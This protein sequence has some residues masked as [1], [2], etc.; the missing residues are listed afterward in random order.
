MTCV[1]FHNS[2]EDVVHFPGLPSWRQLTYQVK[3]LIAK[4][5]ELERMRRVEKAQ[6]KETHKAEAVN[7]V[8]K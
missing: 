6:Q 1:C 4:E 8:Q 3:Q 7:K 5:T 2:V